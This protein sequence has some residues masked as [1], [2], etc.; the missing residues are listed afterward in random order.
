MI[1]IL[2]IIIPESDKIISSILKVLLLLLIVLFPFGI[3]F[4][5]RGVITQDKFWMVSVYLSLISIITILY[6]ILL[7]KKNITILII[8]ILFIFSSLIE[9]FGLKTGYPF[10]SYYYSKDFLP[11]LPGGVPI[12]IS[13]SWL[14]ISINS[15]IICKYICKKS[16]SRFIVPLG[17]AL[18]IL[19]FDILLEP[20]GSFVNKYWL[21]DN[22][23]VPLQ[24]FISWFLI[25]FAFVYLL[26]NTIKFND[27]L[28]NNHF[29]LAFILMFILVIQLV[30]V[31]FASGFWLYTLVGL[32]LII[33]IIRTFKRKY[34][35]AV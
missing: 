7:T 26:D 17:S 15:F 32:L 31:N 14:F 12:A 24:N 21:W 35:D 18:I 2:N 4:M 16:E 23:Y 29:L 28:E 30:I 11:F 10:G 13:F 9:T 25:G 5:I 1:S 20:F 3:L 34:Y 8:V 33:S 27:F 19:S 22:N 6:F